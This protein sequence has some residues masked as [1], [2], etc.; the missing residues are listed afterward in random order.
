[1]VGAYIVLRLLQPHA[2]QDAALKPQPVKPA[3]PAGNLVITVH[4]QFKD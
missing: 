3:A 1:M 4:P 2:T